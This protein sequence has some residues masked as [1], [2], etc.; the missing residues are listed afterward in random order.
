MATPTEAAALGLEGDLQTGDT[1]RAIEDLAGQADEIDDLA[2]LNELNERG[3]ENLGPEEMAEYETIVGKYEDRD[4]DGR[5]IKLEGDEDEVGE[6]VVG[7]V[8]VDDDDS[9]A[10]WDERKRRVADLR[11]GSPRVPAEGG[12][13]RSSGDVEDTGDDWLRELAG[14]EA[15][16]VVTDSDSPEVGTTEEAEHSDESGGVDVEEKGFRARVRKAMDKLKG[17]WS[18]PD[19]AEE[20]RVD[21]ESDSFKRLKEKFNRGEELEGE[22]LHEFARTFVDRVSAMSEEDLRAREEEILNLLE[23]DPDLL[24]LTDEY[25]F[26]LIG[27]RIAEIDEEKESSEDGEVGKGVEEE[28]AA[29]TTKTTEDEVR[30]DVKAE[31]K[32][33]GDFDKEMKGVISTLMKQWAENGRM[34]DEDLEKFGELNMKMILTRGGNDP[35]MA[36]RILKYVKYGKGFSSK[37]AKRVAVVEQTKDSVARLHAMKVQAD[38]LRDKV[39]ELREEMKEKVRKVR[40]LRS[41]SSSDWR[42]D[43]RSELYQA[44]VELA[45]A[46][47]RVTTAKHGNKVLKAEHMRVTTELDRKLGVIGP[48]NMIYQHMKAGVYEAITNAIIDIDSL[49]PYN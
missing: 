27:D 25:E 15:E 12:D 37:V 6:G 14:E 9:P 31:V 2:R 11:R 48:L 44:Y 21:V 36:D 20:D 28:E 35:D 43:S 41:E 4:G 45:E 34:S 16:V 29:D 22:E 24:S 5:E 47:A 40:K 3:V 17:R 7:V 10:K 23:E 39:Y 1:H 13:D 46:K 8:G 30:K 33:E 38:S 42:S 18:R 32:D 26:D 19:E 49:N